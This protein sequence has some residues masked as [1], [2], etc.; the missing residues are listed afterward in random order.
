MLDEADT[1]M[2]STKKLYSVMKEASLAR[3]SHLEN[4]LTKHAKPSCSKS[5]I[6]RRPS[7][8]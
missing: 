6:I 4:I 1:S 5:L 7:D 3:F 8:Y 2:F